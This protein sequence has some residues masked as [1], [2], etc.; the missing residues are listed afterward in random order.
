MGILVV[1]HLQTARVMFGNGRRVRSA[2]EGVLPSFSQAI[3]GGH[4]GITCSDAFLLTVQRAGGRVL[5]PA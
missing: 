4:R 3:G 1:I 5:L 2:V